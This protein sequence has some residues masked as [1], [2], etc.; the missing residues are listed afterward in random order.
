MLVAVAVVNTILCGVHFIS[1]YSVVSNFLIKP[2]SISKYAVIPEAVV[3]LTIS[4]SI[5][6]PI[7]GLSILFVFLMGNLFER[8]IGIFCLVGDKK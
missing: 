2:W 6:R 1:T 7:A 3:G 4:F 5:L 8:I